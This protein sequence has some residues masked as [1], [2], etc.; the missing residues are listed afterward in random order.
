[1]STWMTWFV[2][3]DEP[4][5]R[6]PRFLPPS[7]SALAL[8][9]SSSVVSVFLPSAALTV[10]PPLTDRMFAAVVERN[11]DLLRCLLRPGDR[12]DFP[13]TQYTTHFCYFPFFVACSAQRG[14]S[15]KKYFRL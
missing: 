2:T 6:R 1:M 4:V 13:L 15:H 14:Y 10:V 9:R 12:F 8:G 11:D 7:P 5:R 3:V